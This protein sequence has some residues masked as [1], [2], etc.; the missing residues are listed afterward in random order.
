MLNLARFTRRFATFDIAANAELPIQAGNLE[1]GVE[2]QKRVAT[3]TLIGLGAFQQEAMI[4][5]S[6]QRT[7]CFDSGNAVSKKLA[8]HRN[9]AN[10]GLRGQSTNF[11]QGRLQRRSVHRIAL[12]LRGKGNKKSP[13][14]ILLRSR[15][16]FRKYKARGATLVHETNRALSRIPTYPRQL[17]YALTSHPTSKLHS[18]AP[19]AVH[20]ANGFSIRIPA[21]RTLCARLLALTSAS[22]VW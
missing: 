8:F 20:L 6:T 22:T 5:G 2:A 9:A 17:T 7:H 21:S 18:H 19:S 15:T 1:R 13:S 16:G 11:F 3:P 14:L 10:T 4:A 12:S